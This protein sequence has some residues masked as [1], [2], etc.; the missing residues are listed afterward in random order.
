MGGVRRAVALHPF[1]G[2]PDPHQLFDQRQD[3]GVQRVEMF[4]SQVRVA[5][6]GVL[7]IH[8]LPLG[9]RLGGVRLGVAGL[10]SHTVYDDIAI[11]EHGIEVIEQRLDLDLNRDP[12]S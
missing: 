7:A 12:R 5:D 1:G 10:D 9:Q 8:A 11:S 2:R 6:P 4:G 3:S